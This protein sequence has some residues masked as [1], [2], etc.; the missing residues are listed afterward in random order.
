MQWRFPL[1][2]PMIFSMVLMATIFFQ[3]ESPRWLMRKGRVQEAKETI[4]MLYDLPLDDTT[5]VH[6][7]EGIEASLV[8]S[9]D[10]SV[11]L[12]DLFTSKEDKLLYRFS[13]CIL[14]QFYQQMSGSNLIS[15]YTPV[16]FQQGL[17][18]SSETSRILA[19]AA[20]T[21]KFLSCFVAFFTID[22]F[23]RRALFIFSGFVSTISKS[24][25]TN[26]VY[27]LRKNSGFL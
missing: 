13:L 14:L 16:I 11:S 23:G 24:K 1:A 9:S 7:I 2:I 25:S 4:S 22:R 6:A 3:P 20:L 12:R 19:G 8:E 5:I 21:W 18:M 26:Q 15:V 27:L 10:S 17:S